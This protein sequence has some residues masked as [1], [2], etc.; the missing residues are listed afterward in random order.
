MY[1]YKGDIL[2][3]IDGEIDMQREKLA[4]Q[5]YRYFEKYGKASEGFFLVWS[6]L[7]A[8]IILG[9]WICAATFPEK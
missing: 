9:S 6:L 3:H 4:V 7:A 2:C 8:M 5:G 1:G